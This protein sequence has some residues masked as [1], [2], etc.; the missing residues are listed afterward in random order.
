MS[1][2]KVVMVLG[3]NMHFCPY[4]G[5]KVHEDNCSSEHIIPLSLG[6]VNGFEIPVDAEINKIIGSQIDGKLSN[7]FIIQLARGRLKAK[8]H[9]GKPV[10]PKI[11][12]ATIEGNNNPISLSFPNNQLHIYDPRLKA[13]VYPES[14]TLS[15]KKD[16]TLDIKFIAKVT[17]SA[18]YYFWSDDFEDAVSCDQLRYMLLHDNLNDWSFDD[19]FSV[20]FETLVLNNNSFL[21]HFMSVI[22]DHFPDETTIAFI[23]SYESDRLLVSVSVL[24]VYLGYLHVYMDAKKVQ[25]KNGFIA[26]LSGGKIKLNDFDD[27][28]ASTITRHLNGT[29]TVG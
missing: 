11:T 22:H 21:I 27:D 7:D 28:T 1:S 17:L 3:V 2:D 16:A 23:P 26:S 4:L 13:D 5:K 24:G 10:V 19:V 12:K 14:V 20:K 18:G 8:G 6:G 9:S 15:A 25:K 29:K